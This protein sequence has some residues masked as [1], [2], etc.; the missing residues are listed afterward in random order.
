MYILGIF[1]SA[2]FCSYFFIYILLLAMTLA[3]SLPM[4]VEMANGV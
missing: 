4:A 3:H 2:G 1:F